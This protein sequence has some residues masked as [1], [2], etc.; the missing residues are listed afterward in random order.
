[1]FVTA[2][3][4]KNIWLLWSQ[5]LKLIIW[6]GL[7]LKLWRQVLEEEGHLYNPSLCIVLCFGVILALLVGTY[8]QSI[9][10]SLIFCWALRFR[11][12]KRCLQ[13]VHNG[14]HHN[15]NAKTRMCVCCITNSRWTQYRLLTYIITKQPLQNFQFVPISDIILRRIPCLY[16][17]Q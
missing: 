8:F 5:G 6:H 17:I 2:S 11:T 12:G 13:G 16:G 7:V 14:I 3:T 10:L 9:H 1:M 15:L 4:L